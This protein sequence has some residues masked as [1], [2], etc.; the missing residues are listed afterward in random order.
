MNSQ[1]GFVNERGF[2][3][4]NSRTE[5]SDFVQCFLKHPNA[6]F[7]EVPTF[8]SIF[9]TGERS[10]VLLSKLGEKKST[11]KKELL[12]TVRKRKSG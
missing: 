7:G 9:L 11:N 6:L 1:E 2:S 3:I 4:Y 8:L 10:L 12:S 5:C